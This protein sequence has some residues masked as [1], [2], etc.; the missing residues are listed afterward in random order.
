M[1][2]LSS[3]VAAVVVVVVGGRG[4]YRQREGRLDGIVEGW[5][6]LRGGDWRKARK[7]FLN[8]SF[9]SR[10]CLRQAPVRSLGAP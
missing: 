8:H 1:N 6:I 4:G 2:A 9:L 5:S 10:A 7:T 3:R